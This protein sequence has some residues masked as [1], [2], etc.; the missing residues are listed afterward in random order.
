M[1]LIRVRHVNKTYKNG[2]TAI[3]DLDLTIKK[4]NLFLSL[5]RLVVESLL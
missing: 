5:A 4:E 1:D 3:Y 2:V